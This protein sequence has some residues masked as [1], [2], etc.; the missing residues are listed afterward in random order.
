MRQFL[1]LV[2]FG[3]TSAGAQMSSLPYWRAD[4]LV[5]ISTD[6]KSLAEQ[7]LDDRVRELLIPSPLL[8]AKHSIDRLVPAQSVVDGVTLEAPDWVVR[9]ELPED[10][11]EHAI[12]EDLLE[13][14]SRQ[15]DLAFPDRP[16]L[17]ALH[18]AARPLG[19]TSAT[20]TALPAFLRI[21]AVPTKEG[22][23]AS[24]HSGQ[25]P[26]VRRDRSGA[27]A[28]PLDGMLLFLSQCH[29]WIDYDDSRAWSTQRGITH[30]IVE[31]FVNP[32]AVN[33]YLIAYLENAGAQVLTAR[34][35]DLQTEMV[36]VDEADTSP[37]GAY[38]ESGDSGAFSNSG[39]NGF[40]GSGPWSSSANPFAT[41]T[42]RLITT[43]A[44]ETARATWTPT[45][46]ATGF[47]AVSISYT[48]DGSQRASDAHYIVRHS[49]GES[50]FRVD[51]E[52]HG[53]TWI[54][55]GVFHFEAG[56]DP[57]QASVALANDSLEVGDTV[58]ADAVRFGGGWG[59]VLG[60]HHAEISGR[61]RWEEGARTFVQYLGA[62]SSVWSGGDVSARSRWA[63]WEH[64]V[65]EDSLYLSWHSN[66]FD[67]S[68]R[69]TTTYTYSSNPPDGTWDPTESVPGSAELATSVHDEIVG[70][71]RTEWDP[72][73]QDRG[74]RS[75]Y[76]GEVNPAHNDEMPSVL[77]EV[78][79][80]DNTLDAQEL[81]H[82][83]FRRLL[84]R[85]IAQGIVKFV[86]QRDGTA[87]HL[88]PEPPAAPQI[89]ATSPT[90]ASITWLPSPVDAASGDA[91][92][93]YRVSTSPNGAGF[94]EGEAVLDTSHTMTGLEPGATLF[95]RVSATNEGGE[96][97]P[98]ETLMVRPPATAAAARVLVVHGFD[99]LDRGLL[100]SQHEPDLGGSVLRM[101][102]E[103]MNAGRA[104]VPH[105]RALQPLAVAIDSTSNE[106]LLDGRVVLDPTV[107]PVALWV[108]GEES[109]AD[110]TF[111]SA[112]QA[113][114]ATY[115]TGGGRLVVSGAEIGWDLD[116]LGSS[117]DQTFFRD[118]LGARYI[119]DSSGTTWVE[120]VSGGPLDGIAPWTFDDGS[121]PRIEYPDVLDAEGTGST[122]LLYQST[123]SAACVLSPQVVVL[124]FPFEGVVPSSTRDL[125]LSRL[126]D[127][128]RIPGW[129]LFEDG[130]ESG[131]SSEWSTPAP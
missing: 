66:A 113:L 112:E 40:G 89:R 100:L 68:A 22:P 122:C 37:V 50:H 72:Q 25:R 51:Q 75:A 127:A 58:S 36:I 131:D 99:R 71:I 59:D 129:L 70:D 95:V 7:S 63:A 96:S 90:S 49:G 125:V 10:F 57:I 97:L 5:G 53:W 20:W 93:G 76:F 35:R 54:P 103:R 47:Y 21:E 26:H 114:V 79:F 77:L 110:E 39:Q 82:P 33:Q 92:T 24:P 119:A 1:L 123:S 102:L 84:A 111:S 64:F 32:E 12:T 86:A 117:A 14:L 118:V 65:G 116:W 41:G 78:A 106:A 109:T 3:A 104:A 15:L 73:W 56:F 4:E 8:V 101:F 43:A 60:E 42:A 28:G 74:L 83:R 91:A 38:V 61:P 27:P 87:P 130:F 85:A 31:D 13:K 2:L 11:L 124:G 9:I 46:P 45:I 62:P 48:R 128:L 52:R 94:D 19:D 81:S 30:S 80:H 107:Y 16:E 121:G 55:L 115:L 29:G 23:G 98:G 34:E 44:A 105:G 69:G 18:L 108:L 6:T 17:R 67:G 88:L 126:L 120:P